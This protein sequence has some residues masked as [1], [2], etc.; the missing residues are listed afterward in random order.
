MT[1]PTLILGS[2]ISIFLGALFHLWK[3]GH[4]GRL[5]LYL[6][7]SIVGFWVGHW[8]AESLNWNFDKLGELH[9]AFGILGSLILLFTGYWLSLFDRGKP[10][11]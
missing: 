11:K 4:V 5:L 2:I 9:I 8:G 10:S 7:L 6:F 3:G 1:T